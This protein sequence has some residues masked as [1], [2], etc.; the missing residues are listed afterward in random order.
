MYKTVVLTAFL[1]L[2]SE[3]ALVADYLTGFASLP[4]YGKNCLFSQVSARNFGRSFGL[5]HL[6]DNL[7]AV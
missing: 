4:C 6:R 1:L 5:I 7:G 3:R 2:K